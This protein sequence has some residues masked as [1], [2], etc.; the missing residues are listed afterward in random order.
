[1]WWSHTWK[2]I[3]HLITS[4]LT[5]PCKYGTDWEV[6]SPHN[7]GIQTQEW[8]KF[9]P[10]RDIK[11]VLTA[12]YWKARIYMNMQNCQLHLLQVWCN[13]REHLPFWHTSS[14]SNNFTFFYCSKGWEE[15]LQF[16]FISLQEIDV[17]ITWVNYDIQYVTDILLNEFYC[18]I[19][20]TK[21]L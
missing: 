10:H 7:G 15:L 11:I 12:S 2:D 9:R 18:P 21:I 14:I 4:S 3:P 20:S 19:T 13:D 5:L 6:C 17:W 1:M 8:Q 16:S